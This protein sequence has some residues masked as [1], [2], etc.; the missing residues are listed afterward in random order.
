[1]QRVF[2]SYSRKDQSF[3]RQL[4]RDLDQDGI[5][6]WIDMEI[7]PGV[8]WRN[9]IQEGLDTCEVLIL[10]I[11]PDSMTSDNVAEEW[12]YFHGRRKP[13][14]PLLWQPAKKIHF[15]LEGIQ[16][17]DFYSQE[18][19]RAFH[20][21]LKAL[22]K[23]PDSE[24]PFEW[25]NIPAGKVTLEK[26]KEPDSE[27]PFEW[28]NIPA[29]KVTLENKSMFDNGTKGG[30]YDIPAFAIAKYPV[31]NA[32]YQ[33]FVDAPDGYSEL[34]WWD[35]SNEAKKWRN[36]HQ[37]PRETAFAGNELPRTTVCWYDAVAFCHWISYNTRQIITL[38]TEQQWQRAAQGDNG[39]AYPWGN[40]FDEKRC[41]SSLKEKSSGPTPVTQYSNGASQYEVMDLSGNV[42]EWCLTEWGT[43]SVDLRGS[44][45]RVFRG[46]SWRSRSKDILR[47]AYRDKRNP[48]NEQN[49]VGFRYVRS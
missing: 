15:Q 27:D 19:E 40:K 30:T 8:R 43:D 25:V 9:A 10:V 29:G 1:M 41:N 11:S 4:A 2:I 32:Q 45:Q 44:K 3:V 46:G 34:S 24:D 12:Q 18:Y 37:R 38:P 17:I 33:L 35:Y 48:D 13:I 42:W 31:T 16:Y 21:L 26:M 6:V 23:T 36:E 22:M 28:V 5:M 7:P 49:N 47:S 20:Q 39:W 14:I